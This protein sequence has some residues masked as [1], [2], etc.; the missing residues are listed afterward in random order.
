M[1]SKGSGGLRGGHAPSFA[2]LA[3]VFAAFS[4][5]LSNVG[6]D[7]ILMFSVPMLNALYPL[8][9]CWY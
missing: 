2:V 8:P 7:V 3:F 9:S 5:V 1:W 4:C 6:L